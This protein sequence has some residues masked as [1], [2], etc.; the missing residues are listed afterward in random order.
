MQSYCA[1]LPKVWST[2]GVRAIAK[3]PRRHHGPERA[4][5]RTPGIGQE[6]CDPGEGLVGFGVEDVQDGADQ[7]R[8][9][10][11]FPV[12][13]PF[14]RPFRIDQDVGD[15]LDVAYLGVA[16]AHF[17]QRIVPGRSRIGRIEQQHAAEAGT[18]ARRQLPVL[19]LDVV[20]DGR[21]RPGQKRRDDQSD[22][23]SRRV[24]AKQ[25]TCS[26]PLCRR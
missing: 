4:L 14:E 3:M 12:I 24:G 6:V 2:I 21:T 20:D 16:A 9:T 22:A 7:E 13:A 26:G 11:L 8:V 1:L 23:L 19:T 15:V 10:G 25:R 18:P 17:E 5:D